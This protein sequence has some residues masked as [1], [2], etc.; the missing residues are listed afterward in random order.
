MTY[1]RY[2][3]KT[4]EYY[5]KEGYAKP[6][7][8]AHF[9]DVPFTPLTKPLKD[10]R[11]TLVSTSDVA[12]KGEDDGER[13]A[14][15]MFSGNVYSIPSDTP[16]ERLFSRQE[17]F[18]RYATNLDDVNTYFPIDRLNEAAAAGRIG[19]VAPRLHG[20]FTAYSQRRT[21]E[22]DGPEVLR[23]CREDNVDAAVL[24]PV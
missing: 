16:A 21:L 10:C 19:S 14:L 11:L 18:D 17:H 20:V 23:L 24:T 7:Q 3:D 1:V 5:A 8:W 6:Y 4:R 12:M 2:I 9:D 22:V 15:E 13:D